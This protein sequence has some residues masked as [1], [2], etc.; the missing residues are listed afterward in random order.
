[1][2]FP[3]VKRDGEII[4]DGGVLSPIPVDVLARAGASRII[5]VN[6]I[7][8]IEVLRESQHITLKTKSEGWWTWLKQQ[9]L[10]FGR[11]NIL[12]T[13]MRSLQAMQARLA[14]SS[15]TGADVVINPIVSTEEWFQFDEVDTFIEQGELTARQNLNDIKTLLQESTSKQL[16][17]N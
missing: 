12:D 15:S 7:P 5:A 1:M 10:P 8:P 2:V 17:N 9:V 11:G 14:S 16:D 6:P 4:V 3:P 13:F